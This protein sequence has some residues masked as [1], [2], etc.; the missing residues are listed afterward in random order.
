VSYKVYWHWIDEIGG[1]W[2][3]LIREEPPANGDHFTSDVVDGMRYF[4][5]LKILFIVL[6]DLEIE[7]V[8]LY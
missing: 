3:Y 1:Y 4:S 2:G 7:S 6:S 8:L 5:A